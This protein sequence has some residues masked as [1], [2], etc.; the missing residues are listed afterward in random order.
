MKLQPTWARETQVSPG[1]VWTRETTSMAEE[2]VKSSGSEFRASGW[3][4]L[5][6]QDWLVLVLPQ[7]DR[8]G[9][10]RKSGFC[11]G[12]DKQDFL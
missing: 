10:A 3:C 6:L 9:V 12:K 2:L 7:L 4:D 5:I 8:I 1:T 11:L